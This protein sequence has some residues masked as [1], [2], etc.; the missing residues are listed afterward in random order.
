MAEAA[1]RICNDKIVLFERQYVLDLEV[2]AWRVDEHEFEFT[3]LI[4]EQNLTPIRAHKQKVTDPGVTSVVKTVKSCILFGQ[5][6]RFQI[7]RS[8]IL[9]FVILVAILS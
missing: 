1:W 7:P 4:T 9:Q 3:I 2:G 5:S 6:I 8:I